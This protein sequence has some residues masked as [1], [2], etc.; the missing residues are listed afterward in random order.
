MEADHRRICKFQSPTDPNYLILQ[1][2]F[3]TTIEE[4]ETD[5]QSTAIIDIRIR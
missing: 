2:C 4:L 1:R 3:L 5:G